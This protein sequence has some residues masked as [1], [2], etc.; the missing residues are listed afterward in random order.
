MPP[1]PSPVARPVRL[2]TT[3]PLVPPEPPPAPAP[4]PSGR[5][6][7][8]E[9]AASMLWAAPWAALGTVMAGALMHVDLARRPQD[10]GYLFATTLAGSWA[11]LASN[12]FAEAEGDEGNLTRRRVVQFVVGALIGLFAQLLSGWMLVDPAGSTSS[13]FNLVWFDHTYTY[14]S[15]PM[16]SLLGYAAYF[17]LVGLAVDWWTMTDR[18][19]KSR[20]RVGPIF[21]AGLLS[22]IPAVLF[23]PP[24]THP[25]AIP[26]A[27]ITSAVVQL[28]SPWN[29]AAAEYASYVRAG[30]KKGRGAKVA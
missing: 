1:R 29:E 25:Y 9:L 3:R 27:L 14:T 22:L 16:P 20:F 17:G 24:S 28:A 11:V 26:A 2:V 21:K 4:L 30:A 5:I 7:V 8:A 18:D 19:R 15:S 23:F 10:L 13:T 12:K 6:R